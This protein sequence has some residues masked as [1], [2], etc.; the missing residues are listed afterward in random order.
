MLVVDDS[1]VMRRSVELSLTMGGYEVA[2]AASG[3]EAVALLDGG[4]EPALVLTDIVMPGM[5]GLELIA[6]ARRRLRFTPIV[7]L[8]TQVARELR[9]EG[10]EAGATA[11]A[12]KPTGG[13][14]LLRLVSRFVAPATVSGAA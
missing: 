13:G 14:E 6:E 3:A 1:A 2:C 5:S 4:L 7:A 11:W 9:D 10:K 12:L 8:T